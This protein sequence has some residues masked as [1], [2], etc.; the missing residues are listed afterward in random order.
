MY[1]GGRWGVRAMS[2]GLWVVHD[3]VEDARERCHWV[4][5]GLQD[6]T[7]M[8]LYLKANH[9]VIS[10]ARKSTWKGCTSALPRA[11]VLAGT[12]LD[13]PVIR[14]TVGVRSLYSVAL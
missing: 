5:V 11:M 3:L 12:R 1:G 10:R 14:S 13:A 8:G 7:P 2:S 6:V 4:L 9:V